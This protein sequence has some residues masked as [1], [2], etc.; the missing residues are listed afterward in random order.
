MTEESPAAPPPP[1]SE[2]AAAA[3]APQPAPAA[4]SPAAPPVMEDDTRQT[5]AHPPRLG[6]MISYEGCESGGSSQH[7]A[8]ITGLNDDGSVDVTVFYRRSPPG[9]LTGLIENS[10]GLFMAKEP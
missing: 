4:E 8:I 7:P 9:F 3:S 6:D 1:T 5:K 10:D 2:T